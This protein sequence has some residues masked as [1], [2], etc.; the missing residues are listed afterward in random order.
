VLANDSTNGL[1]YKCDDKCPHYKSVHICSHIAAAEANGDL[2]KFLEWFCHHGRQVPNLTKLSTHGMPAGADKKGGKV[3]RKK[4][5]IKP[6]LT[7]ENRVPLNTAP[8]SFCL[9]TS[10]GNNT[11]NVNTPICQ[12]AGN[13]FSPSACN[14]IF[15]TSE[16]S[17][18]N[19]FNNYATSPNNT[20]PTYGTSANS[21][22]YPYMWPTFHSPWS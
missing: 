15:K 1:Q 16:V 21:L 10:N 18:V 2:Q 4:T 3:A 8:S 14:G 6:Q 11:S 5:G 19:T 9:S 22:H 7:D 17:H 20:W 13:V 12:S